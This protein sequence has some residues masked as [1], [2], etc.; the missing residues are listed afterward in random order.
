MQRVPLAP[1]FQRAVA[2]PLRAC[3]MTEYAAACAA[4]ASSL[5]L[6]QGCHRQIL[7]VALVWVSCACHV[8]AS[9][10][11]IGKACTNHHTMSAACP[12]TLDEQ[13]V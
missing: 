5:A 9:I 4:N 13:R 1:C 2:S 3:V 8:Q 7:T 10:T 6:K 12:Q 11:C